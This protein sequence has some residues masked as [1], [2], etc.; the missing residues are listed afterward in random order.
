[1]MFP[2]GNICVCCEVDL[3][4]CTKSQNPPKP[5]KPS[6]PTK[7][8]TLTC[9]N[10]Y[11]LW[12]VG[13]WPRRGTGMLG[14]PQG[15]PRQSLYGWATFDHFMH[16]WSWKC[17]WPHSQLMCSASWWTGLSQVRFPS[18]TGLP[19]ESTTHS[20]FLCVCLGQY[21]SRD[22]VRGI[23]QLCSAQHGWPRVIP[24]MT[25]TKTDF[26]AKIRTNEWVLGDLEQL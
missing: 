12:W 4:K 16:S 11:P 9:W 10:P 25:T 26:G 8:L 22:E 18:R 20:A 1:M 21:R 2:F 19:Q 5:A 3:F 17:D 6:K 15:Y 14:K 23:L 24:S 13:V 7:T